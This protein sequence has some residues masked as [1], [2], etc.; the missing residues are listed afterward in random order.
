MPFTFSHPAIVMPFRKW[1]SVSGLIIGSMSPNFEYFFK[2]KIS[3]LYGH[4]FDGIF[5]FDLTASI[6]V[7][8][9]FHNLIRNQLILNLPPV[10]N[11]RF[12][13]CIKFNWNQY[14]I[15]NW[16]KVIT[17]ILIGIVSHILWDSFTHETGY[18]VEK[19]SVL[20]MLLNNIPVYKILQ[21]SSTLIG[22]SYIIYFIYNLPKNKSNSVF[23]NLRYCFF[24]IIISLIIILT[25]LYCNSFSIAI[26]NL[27]VTVI[28]SLFLGLMITSVINLKQYENLMNPKNK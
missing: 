12:N 3:N 14:F 17:S 26:G 13:E 22:I 7:A 27:I 19:I 6:L 1:L 10:L 23:L 16:I 20:K 4:S 5:Y 25:K 9:I 18:F 28:M 24:L 21:H 11:S 2:M 8:F 15:K